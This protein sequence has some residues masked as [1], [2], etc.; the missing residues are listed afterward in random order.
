MKTLFRTIFALVVILVVIYFASGFILKNLAIRAENELR[1]RL[2]AKGIFIDSFDYKSIQLTSYNSAT[3]ADLNLRFNLTRKMY[4]KE[5]YDA[6]F[7]ARSINVRFAN[8][9]NPSLFFA[10]KNFSVFI[11]PHDENNQKTFGKLQNAYLQSRIPLYLKH[12]EESADEILQEIQKLFRE[13][14][15][16]LDINF[17]ADV[18]LG[19]DDDELQVGLYTERSGDITVLKFNHKDILKAAEKFDL[20]LAPQEAEIIARYP[21]KVPAMIKITRDAK[22]LSTYEKSMN[23]NFPEDAYRHIYWSYHL[24][25]EFGPELAKEI[26]DAHETVPGN[27]EHERL[28]DYHNNE[29]ARKIAER[30]LSNDDL[31]RMVMESPDIIRWPADVKP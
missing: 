8:F 6:A 24:T 25:R 30:Y 7:D 21:G 9:N 26:T 18:L 1:P 12:P 27:T 28:M 31:K 10:A 23:K 19:I 13:N 5:S 16:Q 20:D 11:E 4:G 17:R 15:T 29:V 14:Q 3:I 22:R 2:E